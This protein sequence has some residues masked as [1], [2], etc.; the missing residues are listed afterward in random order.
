[1][2]SLS[3]CDCCGSVCHHE[4]H[5]IAIF[6]ANDWKQTFTDYE[7][8]LY[9]GVGE[10]KDVGKTVPP[11]V[12]F[13]CTTCFKLYV[14]TLQKQLNLR[15]A[16]LESMKEELEQLE[17]KGKE[18]E[19]KYVQVTPERFHYLISRMVSDI[20]VLNI[21]DECLCYSETPPNSKQKKFYVF[22]GLNEK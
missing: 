7:L 10:L 4:S 17:G 18:P 9:P 22:V 3:V 12:H 8:S 21:N 19:A 2:G 6:R 1:M 13:L 16:E 5:Q 14:L 15:R 11:K 20:S